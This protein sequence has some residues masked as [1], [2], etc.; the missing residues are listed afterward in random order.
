M[1]LSG[2]L[3]ACGSG[4]SETA[5][6]VTP[7]PPPAE[8]AP[9]DEAPAA[10]LDLVQTG[11][12]VRVQDSGNVLYVIRSR[13]CTQTGSVNSQIV[14]RTK[15]QLRVFTFALESGGTAISANFPTMG[16]REV[17]AL[18]EGH[19]REIPN[20]TTWV[21]RDGAGLVILKG[22]AY[23]MGGWTYDGPT[24][25][26][27]WVS[28]NLDDWQFLGFAPWDGRH[29]AG[30]L[31]HHD[32]LFVVGGDML[33]D[34]WSSADGIT[35]RQE[36]AAAAFPARYTPN[37]ASHGGSL[38][39]YGG[40]RWLPNGW[41]ARGQLDCTAEGFNDVWRSD[42]DGANWQ[43]LTE[44]APWS[45][46]GLVHGSVVHDGEIYMIGGGLKN[47]APGAD[48]TETSAE[49][50]DIWSSP[51]GI[52]WMRRLDQ[53]P[54][55]GRTHFSVAETSF[56]CVVSDGSVGTQA[57]VTNDLFIAPDCI[58]YTEVQDRPMPR[59]HASSFAEFNGTLVITGGPPTDHPGTSIWQYVP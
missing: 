54:F 1:L 42:D 43:L 21:P 14:E 33:Q 28:T 32:R 50:R 27:V 48:Y 10:F 8:V 18:Q 45:G 16:P 19:W 13:D 44:H 57:N 22:R 49:F 40:M 51:D 26:E 25:N 39:L 36:T 58:H 9:P 37:V 11:C 31:V 12:D 35:W 15:D 3:T 20:T 47:L 41:C 29:G 7:P 52:T 24:S 4:G 38:Y 46:R 55:P 59:R 17:R 5:G 6:N 30:W 56:G 34:V 53:F 23:L 2:A